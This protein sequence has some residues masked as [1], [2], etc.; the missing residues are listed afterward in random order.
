MQKERKYR[1]FMVMSPEEMIE[2]QEYEMVYETRPGLNGWID[3]F[4]LLKRETLKEAHNDCTFPAE[5]WMLI[6][7][8]D[9]DYEWHKYDNYSYAD[10]GLIPYE[11]GYW[12]KFNYIRYIFNP[13]DIYRRGIKTL[14]EENSF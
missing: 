6:K 2:G 1:P 11:N 13:G 9:S 8:I 7:I 3:K 5:R 4:R 14:F 12:N 10:A